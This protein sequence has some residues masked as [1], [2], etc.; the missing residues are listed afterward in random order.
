M[1]TDKLGL[2][3][4]LAFTHRVNRRP[5]ARAAYPRP[6]AVENHCRTR[7]RIAISFFLTPGRLPPPADVPGASW[8]AVAERS[9]DTA[10]A[11]TQR[12]EH[13]PRPARTKAAWRCASRRTPRCA[14]PLRVRCAS[15][16]RFIV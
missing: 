7:P 10:F 15:A 14:A 2:E 11:R 3:N 13:S 16:F 12:T 1:H 6:S 4:G 9:G 8:T 5:F